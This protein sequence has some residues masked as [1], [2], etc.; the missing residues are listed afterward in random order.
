[1]RSS[2]FS[3]PIYGFELTEGL[4]NR[5]Q[6]D[7]RIL[8]G[9]PDSTRSAC[10]PRAG[11]AVSDEFESFPNGLFSLGGCGTL[12]WVAAVA[13]SSLGGLNWEMPAAIA[14]LVCTHLRNGLECMMI[15]CFRFFVPEAVPWVVLDALEPA[16]AVSVSEALLASF[17]FS[18]SRAW[19]NEAMRRPRAFPWD[20]P[21]YVRGGSYGVGEVRCH[22]L[23]AA[24]RR[25]PCLHCDE[26]IRAHWKRRMAWSGAKKHT[27]QL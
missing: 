3:G 5:N 18:S 23:S 26:L 7:L 10:L 24:S 25:A 16:C 13:D 1:M 2:I 11:C 8:G 9:E 15:L 14:V 6:P 4:V 20:Q 22:C 12:S 21:P 27:G 17:A 19:S